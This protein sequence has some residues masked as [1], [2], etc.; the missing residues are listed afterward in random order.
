MY[1]NVIFTVLIALL[2]ITSV[3]A[4][5]FHAQGY[6][7]LIVEGTV[8]FNGIPMSGRI[9]QLTFWGG[10]EPTFVINAN[11]T[12]SL[13]VYQL[14]RQAGSLPLLGNHV[15]FKNVTATVLNPPPNAWNTSVIVAN[16]SHNR[17]NLNIPMSSSPPPPPPNHAVIMLPPHF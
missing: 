9:V 12:N 11:V 4:Q 6:P 15:H 5:E 1:R 3:Y 7:V 16:T 8:T 17:M 14:W 10:T 2:M 13:G